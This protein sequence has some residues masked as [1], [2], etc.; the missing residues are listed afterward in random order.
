MRVTFVE[1]TDGLQAGSEEWSNIAAELAAERPELLVTNEMPFGEWIA[2]EPVF[3][4]ASARRSLEAHAVGA[5]ALAALG[6][7]SILSSRPVWSHGRLANEAFVL[8]GEQLMP[9]RYKRYLPSEPGWEE[10][11]WFEP[12]DPNF[13]VHDLGGLTAGVLLC[14][15]A[16]FNEH[17]RDYG[18]NGATLIAIPRATG[19]DLQPWLTAGAMAALVSGSYV[20]SSNRVGQQATGPTFGG[21]GFAYA[22]DGTLLGVTSASAPF[23]TFDLDPDLAAARQRDGYPYYVALDVANSPPG[24]RRDEG[25]GPAP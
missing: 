11:S 21:G 2:S 9:L 23:L 19:P 18:V 3:D 15:E 13:P 22:P 4:A 1:W 16:M 25:C 8:T 17:A 24:N 7:P 12:G 6:I 5:K 10:K 14:T 20:V